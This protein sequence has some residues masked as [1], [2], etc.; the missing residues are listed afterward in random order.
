MKSTQ[1][2]ERSVAVPARATAV[3]VRKLYPP[4]SARHAEMLA[5]SEAEIA[6]RIAQI[7]AEKGLLK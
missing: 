7:L 6:A 2:E 4:V 1:F 3:S 5:G